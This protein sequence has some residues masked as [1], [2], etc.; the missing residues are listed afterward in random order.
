MFPKFDLPVTDKFPVKD[1]FVPDMLPVNP[2]SV[3]APVVRPFF[4]TKFFVNPVVV[5][6]PYSLLNQIVKYKINS[7][8]VCKYVVIKLTVA[9]PL[10]LVAYNATLPDTPLILLDTSIISAAALEQTDP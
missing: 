1:S 8:Y 2:S 3:M 7:Y 9:V 4:T 6:V 10:E 5:T